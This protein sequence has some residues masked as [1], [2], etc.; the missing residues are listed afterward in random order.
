MWNPGS[1]PPRRKAST[2]A[3]PSPVVPTR[4]SSSATSLMCLTTSPPWPRG[5][6]RRRDRRG[7]HPAAATV[8]L[9]PSTALHHPAYPHQLTVAPNVSHIHPSVSPKFQPKK[10]EEEKKTLQYI[11]RVA[12]NELKLQPQDNELKICSCATEQKKSSNPY[13]SMQCMYSA[14]RA[15]Y[16]DKYYTRKEKLCLHACF[17]T[18]IHSACM[19]I[20]LAT[21]GHTCTATLCN[22]KVDGPGWHAIK[23]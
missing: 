3:S 8:H 19:H 9:F 2:L 22:L 6:G 15:R 1:T 21:Y 11:V 20:F 16:I 12:C 7:G 10:R 13:S 5:S 23:S 17:G 14:R 18:V 4:G